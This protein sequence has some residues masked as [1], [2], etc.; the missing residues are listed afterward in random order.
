MSFFEESLKH[1]TIRKDGD[2]LMVQAID[3]NEIGLKTSF[4]SEPI[5][6]KYSERGGSD[7]ELISKFC[8][9]LGLNEEAVRMTINKPGKK[10]VPIWEKTMLTLEEAAAYSGIGVNRLRTMTGEKNCTF[11]CWN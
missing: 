11:V 8:L 9:F 6:E 4:S 10:S 5:D 2:N 7:D 3:P 1:L